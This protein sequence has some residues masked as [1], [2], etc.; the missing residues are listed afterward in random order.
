MGAQKVPW[1]LLWS[2]G[3]LPGTRA[4]LPPVHRLQALHAHETSPAACE[5]PGPPQPAGRQGG[6]RAEQAEEPLGKYPWHKA[7]QA[8][9]ASAQGAAGG[10]VAR[11]CL[12]Y[13]WGPG[14]SRVPSLVLNLTTSSPCS[15]GSDV[16]ALAV[17]LLGLLEGFCP[18]A[19]RRDTTAGF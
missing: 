6:L 15:H 8:C 10:G 13:P 11:S 19:V 12:D 4:A 2:S 14:D 17:R 5:G 16:Q 7:W 3:L 9:G 18:G 1:A